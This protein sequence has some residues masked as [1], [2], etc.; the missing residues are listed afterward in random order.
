MSICTHSRNVFGDRG[1]NAG[2]MVPIETV[3]YVV[4]LML[5][6]W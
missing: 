2:A 3:T 6:Q 5:G 1:D 4:L